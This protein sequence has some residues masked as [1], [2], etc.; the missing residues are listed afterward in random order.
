MLNKFYSFIKDILR[1]NY[2]FIAFL[3]ILVVVLKFPLPYY[4]FTEGGISEVII[5]LM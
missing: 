5:Y 1:E 3:I 2:K 4:I